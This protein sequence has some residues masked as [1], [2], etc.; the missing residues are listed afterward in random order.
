MNKQTI[1]IILSVFL[2]SCNTSKKIL[3]LQDVNINHPELIKV[4]SDI[5]VQP[6]DM[7]SIIVSSKDP[8][9]AALFN[10]PQVSYRAGSSYLGNSIDRLSGYTIDYKGN[11]DF[12]VLGTLHIE[13]LTKNQVATLIK[14]KLIAEDLLKDAVVTVEFMNLYVS[15]L[16]EVS[17]PGK[18]MIERDQ[19]TLLEA[20]SMA[21]DLTIYGKRDAVF[22]IR[23]ENGE[24][25]THWVDLRTK[26]LFES[27]VYY[28]R[29]NDIVYVQPNSVRAGQSTIN[30]SNV[31]SASF[32][33]SVA[34]VLATMAATMGVLFLRR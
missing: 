29:Q 20:I 5:T 11:I 8:Q 7:I 31:R 19:I 12:P 21:G 22:V 23:E 26:D 6:K 1:F 2:V 14:E 3:Y 17:R 4:S 34:S 27:P 10:L 32:W 33:A 15:I 9:L 13:G 24:R 16:G 30:E 25:I 18:F 28:L